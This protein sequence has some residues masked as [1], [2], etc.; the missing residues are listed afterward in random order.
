MSVFP[1]EELPQGKQRT[2]LNARA[3]AMMSARVV[4]GLMGIAVAVFTVG[5]AALVPWPSVR[6]TPPS[7]LVTPVPTAQQLVCPGALLRLGD[8]TGQAA[9][10]ASSLGTPTTRFIASGGE[11]DATAFAQSDAGTGATGDAPTLLSAP[12][13][14]TA[15]AVLLSGAQSQQ[16][17]GGDFVGLAA[18]DCRVAS[19]DTWLVGGATTVGR[20]TLV[21]LAN[22]SEVSATV[23]L[24]LFDERGTISAPG[25]SGILVEPQGQR[26]LS[27][28]G[29]APDSRS[30]VVRVTSRGGQV[31]ATL[32]QS[33][34]R[35][36]QPGGVDLV[37][38]SAASTETVIPGLVVGDPDALGALRSSGEAFDDVGTVLRVLAPGD[39][40]VVATIS[41]IPENGAEPG[42]SFD[43]ELDGGQ[44]TDIP[45]DELA[46]GSY[47]VSVIADAPVV[48]G[49]RVTSAVGERTDFAWLSA[50]APLTDRA[51]LT[52]APGPSPTL[53]L[54]NPSNTDAAVMVGEQTVTVP[55]GAAIALPVT[56]G[57]TLTLSGF[58]RIFAA[59]SYSG[60]GMIAQYAAHPPGATSAPV[61]IY[62]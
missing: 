7:E 54:T 60:D 26:V 28:A 9:T 59:I 50:A 40:A 17:D 27:L 19:G 37:G 35:G 33:I 3:A 52:V 20:T 53:H 51:Q 48:A 38:S 58:E 47:T 32:Q 44:V 46:A 5:A 36:L 39:Q 14:D 1:E 62:R 8:E 41:V 49:V 24:Q 22:P 11:I 31:V 61:T 55:S 56:A 57:E 15:Q 4:T 30:P 6:A 18:A 12:P 10:T 29:F 45:L 34:V 2:P 16:V 21:M 42:E 23:D 43:V 25:T 13:S